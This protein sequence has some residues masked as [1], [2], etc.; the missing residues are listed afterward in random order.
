MHKNAEQ[1]TKLVLT[2]PDYPDSARPSLLGGHRRTG[3]IYFLC[4]LLN[5]N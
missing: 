5:E 1:Y 3:F 2:T 4:I